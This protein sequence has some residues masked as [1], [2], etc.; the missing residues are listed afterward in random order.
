MLIS[1][2]LLKSLEIVNRTDEYPFTIKSIS[3]ITEIKFHPSVTYIVGDNGSGKSTILEAI[4]I[5]LGINPEGGN[6]NIRFSLLKTESALSRHILINKTGRKIKDAFFFRAETM[7]NLYVAAKVDED[8]NPGFSWGA[9]GY[10]D[11]KNKS[12]GEGHLEI[13]S[14][15]MSEGIYLFDE[16]ESGLAVD[17]QFQFISEIQRLIGNGSQVIIATHSPIIL[18]YPD[19]VIYNLDDSGISTIEYEDSKA[20]KLTKLF[21]S[22]RKRIISELITDDE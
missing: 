8:E 15:K 2:G 5:S 7:F 21:M 20:Y 18:S 11:L 4:A 17:K 16:P 10:K 22:H 12:H 3:K 1:K 9:H 19:C 6:K 14:N 13:I